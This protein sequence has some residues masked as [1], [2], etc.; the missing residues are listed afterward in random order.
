MTEQK[1][2]HKQHEIVVDATN[3]VLGRLASF[4]AKQALLN[5]KIVIVNCADAIVTGGKRMVINEYKDIRQKG[6]ASLMGPYFPKSPERI[7]KRTISSFVSRTMRNCHRLR[8]AESPG[9]K[10]P[11]EV[12]IKNN[13]NS[14]HFR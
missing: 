3:A 11:F 12:V 9:S 13:Q 1:T 8:V 14:I 7:L 2:E 6:G 10:H 4:A 5:K